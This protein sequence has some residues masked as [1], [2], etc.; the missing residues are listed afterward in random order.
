MDERTASFIGHQ[1]RTDTSEVYGEGFRKALT[2]YQN[3][4]LDTVL[5]HVIQ[6][7]TLPV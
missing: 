5:H 7:K 6:S 3:L 4:G 2:A 1:I